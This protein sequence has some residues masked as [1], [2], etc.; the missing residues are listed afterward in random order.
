MMIAARSEAI[1]STA[2]V[3]PQSP[4]RK[5]HR[6][7][8]I[9]DLGR[10]GNDLAPAV[11]GVCGVTALVL[12]GRRQ[13]RELSRRVAPPQGALYA[14]FVRASLRTANGSGVFG[15]LKN[16]LGGFLLTVS[17][18]SIV[19]KAS[20]G[21]V[22]RLARVL[23]AH[24]E[25]NPAQVSMSIAPVGWAG[26]FLWMKDSV[27]LT[28]FLGQHRKQ[29]AVYPWD[30]DLPRLQSALAQVGVTASSQPGES[31]A[32]SAQPGTTT[33][34]KAILGPLVGSLAFCIGALAF[35]AP[36]AALVVIPIFLIAGL[37]LL[38]NRRIRRSGR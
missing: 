21:G 28:P 23:G 16:G 4:K 8:L 22:P 2:E 25:V 33:R 38:T 19:V 5:E 10:I 37:Q 24:Y 9:A 7:A 32:A 12:F 26:T 35:H 31:I 29:L 14:A 34:S 3:C 27:I 15:S 20:G 18:D 1:R 17:P 13:Q 6:A 30:G 11:F 36:W